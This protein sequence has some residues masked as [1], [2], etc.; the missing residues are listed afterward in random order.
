MD[1]IK[2]EL[3][4]KWF[5]DLE[6]RLKE[7]LFKVPL[8]W[9][10]RAVLPHLSGIIVEAGGIVDSILRG[11]F[12]FTNPNGNRN[13]LNINNYHEH[14]E[15]RFSLSTKTTLIYQYPPVLL[16]PFKEWSFPTNDPMAKLDWWNAYNKMKHERIEYYSECTLSNAV[17]SL[18]ALHQVLSVLPCFFQST[19]ANN[20]IKL[21]GYGVKSAIESIIDNGK[22]DLPF[23]LESDL[24]ATPYMSKRFPENVERISGAYFGG[25]ER[26]ERFLGK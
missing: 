22:D 11:E 16:N 4:I 13:R 21:G 3:V 6:L 10:H 8:N 17:Y 2:T 14:Y 24:F 5:I 1:Q 7:Y 25:S 12:E 9:N 15:K 20:M 19:L 26:L 23:L 18:C